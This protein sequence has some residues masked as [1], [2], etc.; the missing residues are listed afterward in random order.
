MEKERPTHIE[1]LQQVLLRH[2]E[3]LELL[4]LLD[5]LLRD[6]FQ[7]GV[8]A[9]LDGTALDRH[10]IEE[11]LV[12]GRTEAK[13]A[14]IVALSSFTENVCR[15]VPEDALALGVVEVKEFELA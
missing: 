3:A 1:H 14:T 15:R 10:F 4:L 2:D 8:V 11:T 13:V 5:S 7:G 9:G 12:R 6:L